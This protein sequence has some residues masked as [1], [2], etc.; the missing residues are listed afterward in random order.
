LVPRKVTSL[1]LTDHAAVPP[2]AVPGTEKEIVQLLNTPVYPELTWSTIRSNQ[3]PLGL[4]A[5]LLVSVLNASSGLYVPVK[6]PL[7]VMMLVAAASENTV[8][9]KLEVAPP[10]LFT[11]NTALPAV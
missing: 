8:F 3:V 6:G 5:A 9:T 7:P 2:P 10:L 11:S 1:G 4:M